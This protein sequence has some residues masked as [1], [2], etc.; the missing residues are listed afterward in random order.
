MSNA[1]VHR[2]K[3]PRTGPQLLTEPRTS[4]SHSSL[5]SPFDVVS[6]HQKVGTERRT[7]H[8]VFGRKIVRRS[9]VGGRL[10]TVWGLPCL[11]AEGLNSAAPDDASKRSLV[12]EPEMQSSQQ[13]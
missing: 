4:L 3:R 12:L 11:R 9:G 10:G 6:E 13:E 8:Q 7:C 5:L 1:F 2:S